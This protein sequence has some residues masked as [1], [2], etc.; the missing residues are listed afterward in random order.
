MAMWFT[1]LFYASATSPG[2]GPER[3]RL[4]WGALAPDADKVWPVPRAFTHAHGIPRP[5]RAADLLPA[6]QVDL[7]GAHGAMAFLAG[8]ASHIAVDSVWYRHLRTLK[9]ARPD[10]A[11]GWTDDST[12]AWNLA[13]DLENRLRVDP[14]IVDLEVPPDEAVV[15]CLAG[16]AGRTMR[17]AVGLYLN[18]RDRLE[19]PAPSP[20]LR[21]VLDRFRIALARQQD[22]IAG[23][24][25]I[26]DRRALDQEVLDASRAAA[27]DVFDSLDSS[28]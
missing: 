18:W 9:L 4:V 8:W 16:A 6:L 15:P 11:G 19:D 24:L 17:G 5:I 27:R 25:G 10:L 26:L 20:A 12:R 3:A 7:E 1:H 23:L 13:L 28:R 2:P 21:P 22:R 14:G